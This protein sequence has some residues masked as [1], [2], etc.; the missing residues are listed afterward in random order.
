MKRRNLIKQV[1]LLTTGIIAGNPAVAT[2][3]KSKFTK[4][5]LILAH[6]TDV[7]IRPEEGVPERYKKCLQ[8][9][10]QHKIDFVLNGGDS[11]HAADYPDITRARVD[12]QWSA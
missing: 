7:H 5:S 6:I 10:K 12:E 9:V 8:Q 1:G 2:F 4:P 11:I 3:P